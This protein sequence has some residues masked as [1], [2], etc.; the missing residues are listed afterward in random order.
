MVEKTTSQNTGSDSKKAIKHSSNSAKSSTKATKTKK[1]QSAKRQKAV[2]EIRILAPIIATFFVS[3][4]VAMVGV[5]VNY[6]QHD[7]QLSD[8][9]SSFLASA[10]YIWFVLIAIPTAYIMNNLGHKKTVLLA[11][12]LSCVSMAIPIL[13]YSPITMVISLCTLGIANTIMQISLNLLVSDVTPKRQMSSMLTLGQF[14]GQIPAMIIPLLAMLASLWFGSWRW[15]YPFF[16]A[17]SLGITYWLYRTEVEESADKDPSGIM[18]II[19]LLRKPVILLCFIGI[20]LQV[21]IDVGISITTPK[22]IMERTGAST[23]S[24]NFVLMVYAIVRLIGCLGGAFILSQFSN[25]KIYIASIALIL[26]G[27]AGLLFINSRILIY[28]CTI[29]MGLGVSNLFAILFSQALDTFPRKKNDISV[30]LIMGLVGGAIFPPIMGIG[31]KLVG[32]H[33]FGAIIV[34]MLCAIGML[35]ISKQLKDE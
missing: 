5:V 22:I 1:P 18:D 3:G 17:V 11:L 19:G 23:E 29:F 25:K 35:Y 8:T 12:I 33:Q 9:I 32:G 21:G 20:I 4:L 7:F 14:V 31:T 15:V 30:L 24:A 2:Q 26:L 27:C 28:I 10:I 34:I 6:V 16:L 13:Y